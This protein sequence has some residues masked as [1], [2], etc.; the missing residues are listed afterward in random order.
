MRGLRFRLLTDRKTQFAHGKKDR[1]TPSGAA[2][3]VCDCLYCWRVSFSRGNF[4]DLYGRGKKG[5]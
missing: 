5:R 2:V 3:V 4:G 1:R